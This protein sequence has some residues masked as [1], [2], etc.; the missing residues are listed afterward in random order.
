MPQFSD[1][2]FLGPAITYMGTGNAN[3]SASFTGSI[4]TTTLT[5]TAM[6][7]GDS[8][9]V[10]QYIDGSGVTN[11][12]FITAFGTGTGGTGTYTVNTSQTASSTTMIAN[13]NAFLGDPSP[14]SLGVGPLGRIYVWDT[15]P[16]ALVANNIAASQ[17]PVAAGAVTLTAGTSVKSVVTNNGTVL[18]LDVP[19]AVSVTT[20]TAAVATLSSVA[21]T[22]TGGQISYTSQAGL[23]TGQ[24]VVVSGTLSGT[25]TITGYTNP[26][27]YILTAVTATTAT[28]TTTAGAAVVTTAGT[29]TGLTFTLG[30]APV[31]FTV[32]GYDYYGQAM[33]EAIT[34]SASVSTAVNGKKA[35]YQISSIAVAGATGTAITIGTTDILG[36]PVRVTDAG[37]IARAGYNNTLAEDAGTFVAAA[38]ATATTTTGDVRGTYVPSAATDGIKR[39]V[40]GILLPAIAVGPNAIRVGALGVTQA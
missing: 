12:T 7:S 36:I 4:A 17:T 40:M 30:V 18:Q 9:V 39:V 10:G 1:D 19:R 23:A 14:M 22:G 11:G 20:S 16:Q 26:T 21:V 34:S 31:A 37:Y 6:L 27:T 33:S 13:G 32:S 38:T 15:V 35:F 24:R 8:L 2:L 5:V 25:A 3:A 29:T 28:L